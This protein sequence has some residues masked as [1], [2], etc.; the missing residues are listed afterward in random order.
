MYFIFKTIE[1]AIFKKL[2]YTLDLDYFPY[3]VHE[4]A[5]RDSYQ[6]QLRSVDDHLANYDLNR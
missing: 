2:L 1:I 4:I 3:F 6:S 5:S